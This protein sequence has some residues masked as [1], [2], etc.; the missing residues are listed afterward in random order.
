MSV[1]FRKNQKIL[2]KSFASPFAPESPLIAE[3]NSFF[4][5][6]RLPAHCAD[7]P[8]QEIAVRWIKQHADSLTVVPVSRL[9]C[10]EEIYDALRITWRELHPPS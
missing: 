5:S 6:P 3:L 10:A 1:W 9:A 8:E 7:F 2:L 4:F